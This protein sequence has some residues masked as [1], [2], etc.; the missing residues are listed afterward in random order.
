MS[1]KNGKSDAKIVESEILDNKNM[2]YK[3]EKAIKVEL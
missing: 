2:D 1:Q 3:V